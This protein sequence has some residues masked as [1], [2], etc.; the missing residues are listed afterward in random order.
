MSQRVYLGATDGV[1]RCDGDGCQRVGLQDKRV[2]AVHAWRSD[3]ADVILAGTYEDG[4]FR[5]ADGG[6]TWKQI[7][8]GITAPCFR[9]IQPDPT[10]AGAIICGTEPARAFRSSDGGETWT[11][12]T[13][14]EDVPT[15]HDW[16]LPYSPRAGALR[17]FYSP[18]GRS[19]QLFGAVEVGGVLASEDAGQSWQVLNTQPDDDIH[20]VTGHPEHG[21]VLF[22]ALGWASLQRGNRGEDAP[23]LG[24]VGR[25]D[26]GG[27]TWR[28]FHTDY[29]RAV[30]VPEGYPDLLLAGPAK[31]VGHEGR[32]EVSRD[33]GEN[34]EAASGGLETPMD[35]MVELF[36]PGPGGSVWAICSGGGLL[37]AMPEDWQWKPALPQ[38]RTLEV[39]S[40]SFVD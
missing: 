37:S 34:W 28:K 27:K 17:N 19:S 30:I 6:E 40:V 16:Y 13:A 39:E 22:A 31:R 14:I 8:D 32:I 23:P 38:D 15:V 11:E 36:V 5:S 21:D 1:Y 9:T 25:S 7:T 35:D 26:D 4:L 10:H 12:L 29:T 3:G 2:S 24:G 33:G 20:Y 18:P